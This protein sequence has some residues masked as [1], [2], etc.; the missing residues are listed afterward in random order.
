MKKTLIWQALAICMAVLFVSS[1]SPGENKP[2]SSPVPVVAVPAVKKPVPVRIKA[3]GTVVAYESI[4]VRS[5]VTGLITRVLFREGQD[6]KQGDVLLELDDRTHRADLKQA[7]ANLARDRAQEAKAREDVKRYAMLLEKEYISREQYDQVRA[8]LASLEATVRADLAA[9]ESARVMLQYCTVTSPVSGRTGRLLVDRGN[10][11]K[12]NDVEIVTINRIHPVHV[13]F[14]VPENDLARVRKHAGE[15]GLSVEALVPGDER[16][17]RGVLSFVDNA[18]DRETGTIT[19]KAV[20][21]NV[22]SRLVP[23]QFVDVSLELYVIPD[24]VVVPAQCVDQ[25]QAGQY[26]YVVGKGL[27]AEMR[28]VETGGDLEGEAVILRGVQAGEQVVVEGQLRLTP[29][30]AVSVKTL[31]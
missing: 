8:D 26:V 14:S 19:L 3:I 12:A 15:G 2:R 27:K 25:G 21:E 17:E 24:A 18:V 20:F 23:G 4:S 7:E 9:L 31:K 28:Q 5:Q 11:V 22:D 1:C 6:V 30:A 10:I 16:P 13:S 29:G